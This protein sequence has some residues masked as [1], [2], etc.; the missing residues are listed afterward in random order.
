MEKG[1][2]H[3]GYNRKKYKVV[4]GKNE[5]KESDHVLHG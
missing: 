4:A 3:E 1:R 5:E 2:R